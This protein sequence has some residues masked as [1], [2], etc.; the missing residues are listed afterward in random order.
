ME[1]LYESAT[2]RVFRTVALQPLIC[3]Q[4]LGEDGLRRVRHETAMLQRLEG[5]EGVARLAAGAQADGVIS[6][7]DYGGSTLAQMLEAGRFDAGAIVKLAMQ[8][9]RT[10]AEIHRRGVVHRDVNPNNIL[11]SPSGDAVL[12][13][14]DLA[15]TPGQPGFAAQ[16]GE[17]TGTLAYLAPEQSGRTGRA[18]DQRADLYAFGVTLYEMVTGRLPF[19]ALETLNLIHQ[20]LVIDPVP[21]LQLD[22]RIPTGLSAIVMRLM[23]KA[24][25]QRYQSAGGLLYDLRRVQ[26][27]IEAGEDVAFELGERDFPARLAPPQQLVARDRELATLRAAFARAIDAPQGAVLDE[28]A[29]GVGKSA[30]IHELRAAAAAA[31]GWFVHGKFDQFQKDAA[32]AGA[33]TQTAQALGRLLLALPPQEQAAQRQRILDVLGRNAGLMTRLSPEFG[34][35]LGPHPDVPE[36]DPSQA[37]ERFQQA[38]TDLLTAIVSPERP[39]VVVFDDLHWAGPAS[40]SAFG[41]M[42]NEGGVRGLLLVGAF[43]PEEVDGDHLLAPALEQWS[44]LA[45]PPLRIS[46]DNL[47]E[48]GTGEFLAKMLRLAGDRA[49][50]LSRALGTLSAGNPFDTL[51]MVNALRADGVLGHDDVDWYWNNDQVRHYV[52]ASNVVDLLTARITRLPAASRELME[53]MSCLGNSVQRA[54]LAAAMGLGESELQ[55]RLGATLDDGLLVAETAEGHSVVRFRHDRVQQAVLGALHEDRRLHH[56]ISL[57]RKLAAY[58]ALEHGAAAQ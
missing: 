50:E 2:T 38:A 31:G 22:A 11:V 53:F 17:V 42:V 57:A 37:E 34:L 26:T 28:G 39:L 32:T 44:K 58:P 54:L 41:R 25:E 12:I 6:L 27:A 47:D 18:V 49:L 52:G 30:L 5:M 21:P 35:L 51:E 55:K 40:L 56:Q 8:L 16:E 45:A 4:P 10:L 9:A 46:L 13:D 23:A 43:R 7:H 19:D 15:M 33:V 24:P 48:A 1:V 36:V 3:K 29:A 20:H 14:F